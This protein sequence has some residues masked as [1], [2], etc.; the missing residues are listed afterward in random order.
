MPYGYNI[1]KLD[2]GEKLT[3][4]VC[5]S[6]DGHMGRKGEKYANLYRFRKYNG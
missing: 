5:W 4:G 6:Y 3:V 1:G 2:W